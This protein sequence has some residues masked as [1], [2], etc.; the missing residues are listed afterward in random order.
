MCCVAELDSVDSG[1]RVHNNSPEY[2]YFHGKIN[3]K[4][5]CLVVPVLILID[6]ISTSILTV[7]FL[8]LLIFFFFFLEEGFTLGC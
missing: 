6:E 7:K 3:N 1:C 5:H 8:L 2:K 4:K